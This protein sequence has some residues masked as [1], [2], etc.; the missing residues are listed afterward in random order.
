MINN[1]LNGNTD[2]I[3]DSFKEK[4]EGIINKPNL[5]SEQD[6]TLLDF[7]LNKKSKL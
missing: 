6:E 5:N 4:I 1:I 2:N 3:P 7:N